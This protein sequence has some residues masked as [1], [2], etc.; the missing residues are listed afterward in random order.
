MNG[1]LFDDFCAFGQ[2]HLECQDV[3]PAYPVLRHLLRNEGLA[4]RIESCHHY[5]AWYNIASSLEAWSGGLRAHSVDPALIHHWKLALL[6]TGVERRGLRGGA[7]LMDH[8]ANQNVVLNGMPWDKW[9]AQAAT[10]DQMGQLIQT[11]KGNGRWAAYKLCELMQKVAGLD[12]TPTDMGHEFSSGPRKG[13]ALLYDD[14]PEHKDQRKTS[15][16]RLNELS[17]DLMNRCVLWCPDIALLETLLCDFH[18]LW[19]G[20]FYVGHDTDE[21]LAGI[22]KLTDG[23]VKNRLLEARAAPL[24]SDYLGEHSGWTGVCKDRIRAYIDQGEIWVR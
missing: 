24:P 1:K 20:H 9:T 19:K 6:P 22:N 14:C 15:I 7:N 23:P 10:W 8:L 2:A 18:S 3:D 21:M 17:D 11:I 4:G 13:L 16:A 12:I 5:V